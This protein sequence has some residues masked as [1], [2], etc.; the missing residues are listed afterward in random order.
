LLED[1]M[2]CLNTVATIALVIFAAAN[3][4][5]QTTPSTT[6]SKPNKVT[7]VPPPPPP[8][9]PDKLT[10]GTQPPGPHGGKTRDPRGPGVVDDLAAD[11]NRKASKCYA[12]LG[13]PAYFNCINS[14][15][16][17]CVI[18]KGGTASTGSNENGDY[19]ECKS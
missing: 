2:K 7:S 17:N 4:S 19:F 13:H 6:P 9:G 11:P 15:I 10:T 12:N 8:P 16:T 5:A 3:A 14:L 18:G 1:T